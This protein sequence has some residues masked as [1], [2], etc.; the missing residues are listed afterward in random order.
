M[1]LNKMGD[2][3]LRRMTRKVYVPRDIFEEGAVLLSVVVVT[4]NAY[5]K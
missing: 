2:G 5:H 4:S 1:A 3:S